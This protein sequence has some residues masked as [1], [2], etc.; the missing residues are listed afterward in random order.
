MNVFSGKNFRLFGLGLVLLVIG[1]VF[2]GIG[3]ANNPLSK[4]IAPLILVAVYCVYFPW[5]ILTRGKG[6]EHEEEA[7]KEG[8]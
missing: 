4:T 1:Y 7:Q 3:P 8:V 6:A 2:L 5:A